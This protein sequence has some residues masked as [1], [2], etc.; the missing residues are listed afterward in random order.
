MF[1]YWEN[2]F[3]PISMI[4]KYADF[5]YAREY[6]KLIL[7]DKSKQLCL[8]DRQTWPEKL[9][10]PWTRRAGEANISWIAISKNYGPHCALL[11]ND[12]NH[13]N[14]F[15]VPKWC[16]KWKNVVDQQCCF[17]E[18]WVPLDRKKPGSVVCISKLQFDMK[19]FANR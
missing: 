13:A 14:F 2:S 15:P 8:S 18:N 5:S 16:E 4:R 17:V 3:G 6:W 9:K 7:E 12:T 1:P 19:H 10:P 11:K